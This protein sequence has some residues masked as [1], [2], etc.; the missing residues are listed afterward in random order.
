M[1]IWID[2]LYPPSNGELGI[3]DP[4]ALIKGE[5]P[6]NQNFFRLPGAM[7]SFESFHDFSS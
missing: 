6:P 4:V 3:V 7:E 1:A 2:G 5:T